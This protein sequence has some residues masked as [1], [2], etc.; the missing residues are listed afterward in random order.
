[1]LKSRWWWDL[2]TRDFASVDMS[3]IVA[4]LAMAAVEQ[5]G[6]HG[7]PGHG[8]YAHRRAK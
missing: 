5:H 8:A 7:L 4:V 1:M 3:G 6:P 2:S